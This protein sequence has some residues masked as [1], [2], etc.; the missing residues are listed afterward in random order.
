M[1]TTNNPVSFRLTD[2]E[3]ELLRQYQ[4]DGEKSINLTAKRLLLNALGVDT[5]KPSLQVV[6]TVDINQI[7]ELIEVA[8]QEQL[9]KFTTVDNVDTIKNLIA[10]SLA[11]GDIKY[12]ISNSYTAMMGQFN[13][14][15][16]QLQELKKQIDCNSIPQFPVPSPIII[17][18]LTTDNGELVIDNYQLDQEIGN[19]E[20]GTGEYE[21]V[22]LIDSDNSP[23]LSEKNQTDYVQ[24]QL[25]KNGIK[26]TAAQIRE[27]FINLNFDGTNYNQVRDKVI[28]VLFDK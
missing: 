13:G 3:L 27:A 20:L 22:D 8:V 18:Q 9:T 28:E 5:K 1:T 26:K 12:A 6:N 10:E 7:K 16:E 24:K 17:E 21:N 11:D 4:E 23:A 14:L 2:D 19:R 25:K 15:L